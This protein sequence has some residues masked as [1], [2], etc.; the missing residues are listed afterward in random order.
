M[1]KLS[2]LF[3]MLG[4]VFLGYN[5]LKAQC[6]PDPAYTTPGIYPTAIANGCLNELYSQVITIVVPTDTVVSGFPIPID[7]IVLDSVV[8]LPVGLTYQCVPPSCGFPGGTSNCILI[9]GTP[10]LAD[11]FVVDIYTTAWVTVFGNPVAF[12]VAQP[13]FYEMI[14]YPSPVDSVSIT[15]ASCGANDGMA[16]VYASGPAPISYLWSNGDVTAT[17]DNLAAGAY[18]VTVTNG[19][20]CSETVNVVINSSGLAPEVA[21]DSITWS[22]CAGTNSGGIYISAVGG[23]APLTYSW[24]NGATTEDIDGLAGGTYTV[25]VTDAL[26]CATVEAIVLTEPAP[27]VLDDDNIMDVTCA[28]NADGSAT[29]SVTGGQG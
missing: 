27:L 21:T 12:P 17:S 9:S 3:L 25:T 6:N 14:I 18:T 28:G 11:T 15:P 1:K 13:G 8:N 19:E 23:T 7:S 20:N 22:G 16:T 4:L 2:Y 24:S 5:N 26:G 29:V 10:T